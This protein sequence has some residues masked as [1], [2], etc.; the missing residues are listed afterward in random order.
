MCSVILALSEHENYPLI[1]AANRD[2]WLARPTAPFGQLVQTP[3]AFGGRDLRAQG[4]WFAIRP[5]GCMA[6]VT[7]TRPGNA[8]DTKKKSRGTLVLDLVSQ[9]TLE[10]MVKAAAAVDPQLYNPFNLLF[11]QGSKFYLL[12]SGQPFSSEPIAA[13]VHVLGNMALDSIEDS[14]TAFVRKELEDLRR[15]PKEQLAERLS[16]LLSDPALYL[17][18][19]SYGTRWS[20]VY[21][22]RTPGDGSLGIAEAG[23]QNGPLRKVRVG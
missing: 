3:P 21:L 17:D 14:K 23:I 5:D 6:L 1:V 9:P 22:E 20:M 12:G 10:D 2:E 19:E 18:T 16:T 7:N 13:G 15:W 4:S 8:P 11:G